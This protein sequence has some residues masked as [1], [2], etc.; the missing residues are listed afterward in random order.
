MKTR[1]FPVNIQI[2]LQTT[3]LQI[4]FSGFGSSTGIIFPK[5]VPWLIATQRLWKRPE[6]L[7]SFP[8]SFDKIAHIAANIK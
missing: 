4:L 8:T 6:Y 1:V 7:E 3:G 5:G 2:R